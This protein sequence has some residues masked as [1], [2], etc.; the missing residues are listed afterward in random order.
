MTDQ[1]LVQATKTLE[2]QLNEIRVKVEV[3]ERDNS[4]WT[5]RALLT[6]EPIG[7]I[8]Q[9]FKD[10]EIARYSSSWDNLSGYT[11]AEIAWIVAWSTLEPKPEGLFDYWTI[12]PGISP[13]KNDY[14]ITIRRSFIFYKAIEAL[15]GPMIAA[16]VR[17]FYN[18]KNIPWQA[19]PDWGRLLE[20][21]LKQEGLV[22][23]DPGYATLMAALDLT[24]PMPGPPIYVQGDIVSGGQTGR[25][26]PGNKY[27]GP[28]D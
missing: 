25:Y 24:R 7:I 17:A 14:S 20:Q 2:N 13:I 4:N 6:S 16:E 1:E 21:D 22:L 28:D 12:R 27:F 3:L 9:A 26:S 23:I 11:R 5:S 19:P 8:Y 18:Q 10:W 15:L